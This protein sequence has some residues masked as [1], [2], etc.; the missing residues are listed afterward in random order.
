MKLSAAVYK[1]SCWVRNGK[2]RHCRR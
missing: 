1:L 2:K